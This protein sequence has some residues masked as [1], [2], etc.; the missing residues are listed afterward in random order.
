MSCLFSRIT[1]HNTSLYVNTPLCRYASTVRQGAVAK[2]RS[3][4][5][6]KGYHCELWRCGLDFMHIRLCGRSDRGRGVGSA[7]GV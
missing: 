5:M 6:L 4:M 7:S 3:V 2:Q 1:A